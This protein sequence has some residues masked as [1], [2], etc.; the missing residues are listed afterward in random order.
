MFNTEI[1]PSTF[2]YI[3]I[4]TVLLLV[5]AINLIQKWNKTDRNYYLKYTALWLS[6]LIYNLVEGLLP[7]KNFPIAILPQ[8]IIAWTIG[9][10]V[11]YHYLVFLKTEYHVEFHKKNIP[12]NTIGM[13]A[14]LLF[15]LLFILPYTITKSIEQSRVFFVAFFLIAL[16]IANL[17]FVRQLYKRVKKEQNIFLKIHSFNGI[18]GFIGLFSLPFTIMAFGDNQ[19]I[20]QTAFSFGFFAVSIDYFFY[21]KRKEEFKKTVSFENLTNREGEILKIM[22][23]NPELKYSQL[24]DILNIS[25]KT[26]STHLSNIY[27][28]TDLNSKKDIE[29]LSEGF[30]RS[31]VA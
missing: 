28:K 22:L 12:L 30:R 10:V 4:F 2:I 7:D 1:F 26:L 13:V 29:E 25:E 20:E 31:V 18:L 17:F 19:L 15:V 5:G 16:F 3:I 21:Y 9:I 23:E 14:L 24:S 11:A 6:G 8:N 27:K